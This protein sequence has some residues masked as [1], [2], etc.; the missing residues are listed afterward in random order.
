[1]A[2]IGAK[3]NG[4][5]KEKKIEVKEEE[6]LLKKEYFKKDFVHPV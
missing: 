5:T 4:E 6:K 3:M 1:M 2:A